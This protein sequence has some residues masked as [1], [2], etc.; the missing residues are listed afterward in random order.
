MMMNTPNPIERLVVVGAQW[1]DEGKAK[2]VDMLAEYA[3][4]VIRSQGGCNAGHT[5]KFQGETFKFH[6]LPSGL[7]YG[8]KQCV[9]GSGVVLAPSILKQELDDIQAKGYTTKNLF[10]SER[11]H[12]TFPY[13]IEQ[14]QKQELMRNARAPESRIG[15]TGRG[16]GPTYMDKVGRIGLRVCDMMEPEPILRA[17]IERVVSEKG[18]FAAST[19]DYLMN[20]CAEYKAILAPYVADTVELLQTALAGKKRLLFEGAQGTLLDV[21]FGT[22]PFVTSSNSTSGGAC[23]GT[24]VG[25]SKI[26]ATLGVMKAYLTRVGA[27]P[28]PT[29]QLNETGEALCTRGHEFG[30]TTGRKRRT[31]WFDGVVGR[32][33]VEVNGLDGIALTKLDVLDDFDEIAIA[34]AYRDTE[35]GQEYTR[36]PASLHVLERLEPVYTTLPG[37]KTDTSGVKHYEDLPEACKRYIEVLETVCHCP[38]WMVS[39]GPDRSETMMRRPIF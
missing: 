11:C 6:H 38:V 25:P 20:V 16:I 17:T 29:E 28:F 3:D 18:F 22:Y 27:G 14:D 15:T 7:L 32:Y 21:D 23:T 10:I 8:D 33:S 24:G 26:D 39:V 35:T 31:G 4:V 5:V 1:G 13:H 36:F 9:I 34:T 37:W 30:T 19:V 12:I 2:V